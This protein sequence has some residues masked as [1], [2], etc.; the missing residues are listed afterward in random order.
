[1]RRKDDIHKRPF[2]IDDENPHPSRPKKD[3]TKLEIYADLKKF[4]I[5]EGQ[6][7][8]ADR[9]KK[10]LKNPEDY[11]RGPNQRI[12]WGHNNIHQFYGYEQARWRTGEAH[13][14]KLTRAKRSPQEQL[15]ILDKRGARAKRERLRL[16]KEIESLNSKNT[17]KYG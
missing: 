1:M 13:E 17:S 4:Y 9:Y 15:A 11:I 14:R 2:W 8:Y 16:E 5:E 10:F 7:W 12:N 6:E 3:Q